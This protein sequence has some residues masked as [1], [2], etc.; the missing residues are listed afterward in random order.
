MARRGTLKF[1]ND[2]GDS[3]QQSYSTAEQSTPRRARGTLTFSEMEPVEMEKTVDINQLKNRVDSAKK[4]WQQTS[5]ISAD[6]SV[7]QSERDARNNYKTLLK[8]YKT[9]KA[10]QD[11]EEQTRKAQQEYD[12]LRGAD[13]NALKAKMDAAKESADGSAKERIV[14]GSIVKQKDSGAQAVYEE[15]ARKYNLAKQIQYDERGTE[16]LSKLSEEQAAAVETLAKSK[17]KDRKIDMSGY[18]LDDENRYNAKQK[19]LAD[20]FTEQEI[21]DLED[22]RA[23]QI[24]SA[25]YDKAVQKREDLANSGVL[26]AAVATVASVPE[27]LTS[28]IGL[29]D[30]AMQVAQN[31]GTDRPANYKRTAMRPYAKANAARSTISGNL[32]Q[33][34][35]AEFLGQNVASGAYNI[36]TSMLD[37]AATLGLTALGIPPMA[38]TSLLGGAAATSAMVDAHE[39]GVSDEQAV[40]SGAAAGVAETLFEEVSLEKLL[41][42]KPV[43]GDLSRRVRTTLKNIGLQ[44]A[45]EGSEEV[46]TTIANTV[47]DHLINGSL[48]EMQ[49]NIKAYMDSGMTEGEARARAYIDLGKQL[50][51]DFTGGAISGGIMSGVRTGIETAKADA[52]LRED[53]GAKPNELIEEG[54]ATDDGSKA[55]QL[56]QK[57]SQQVEGGK[58]LSQRQVGKLVRANEAYFLSEDEATVQSAVKQ[59]LMEL[60]ETGDIEKISRALTRQASGEDL[61]IAD[62]RRIARSEAA[63][64]ISRDLNPENENEWAKGIGT[65]KLNREAYNADLVDLA[66]RKAARTEAQRAA[67]A[68]VENSEGSS[69]A[70]PQNRAVGRTGMDVT[71]ADTGE[72]LGSVKIQ[73]IKDGKL[74]L[75]T[76]DGQIVDA[77]KVKFRT[78]GERVVYSA[79]AEMNLNPAIAQSIVDNYDNSV[80]GRIYAADVKLAYQYGRMNFPKSEL[81]KLDIK[82]Y[83]A[84]HAYNLGRAEVRTEQPKQDVKVTKKKRTVSGGKGK[85]VFETSTDEKAMTDIQRESLNGIKLLAELSNVEFH[86]YESTKSGNSFVYEKPDGVKT[87]A[88]GWY[89]TGTNQIWVD[90]NAGN[91]GEGT[92]L[93]T[94]AHEISHYIKEWSPTKWR[95]MADYLI[96]QYGEDVPLDALLERQMEKLRSRN[97]GAKDEQLMDE[98]HEELVSDALSEMLVDGKVADKL[99]ALKKKDRSLWTKIK[100]AVKDLLERWG[101]IRKQYEGR[102]PDAGEAQF[103]RGMDEAFS[104]IQTMYA[105][106]FADADVNF[107]QAMQ[108]VVKPGAAAIS[109]SEILT[110]GAV[111]TDGETRHSIRS[112]KADIAEGQMFEDLKERCGWSQKQVDELRGKLTELVAYMEP[113]REILD[114]NEAYGRAGRRY[115]PYKPNSDPLY[116][117]SMDFSTLCSKR[118]LTQYVIESLQVRE[119]RPMSAEEQM[120][121]RDMLNEYRQVEKGLQVACAMCYVEAARLKS[122]KQIQRWLDDPAARMRDYL[123]PNN[124][125]FK[126]KIAEM[127]ADF[128]ESLGYDRS[129][130]QTKM[131]TADK[132]EL[133]RRSKQ[134]RGEYQPSAEEQKII[135][136]AAVLPK[137]TYLTAANLARLR[138]TD[139]VI[140]DAYSNFVRAATHS[141]ALETDE[142]YYYGDSARDNGNGIKVSDK[143]IEKVN[144]ENGMRFSSWSDWR[145]QHMLDY[146]TAVIDNS[147]RGAAMHG[148]TKFPDEVRV[149][150]KTGM[151]FNLSGVA[152]TQ[153]GLNPDGSLSFSDTESINIEEAKA[154]REEFPETA[155]LQ[156]IGVSDE[157]IRALMRSEDVDYIIPYHTSS[158]NKDL[159]RMAQIHGWK[160]YT[161]I[162]NAG[163]IKSAKDNGENNWQKEPVFSEFF[164]GYDTG[165]NGIDAMR[166]S[167]KR[168][169]EMCGERGLHPKFEK[170]AD[171]PNY[172]KLLIDRKMVNQNT[173]ELIRQKPVTPT[174]DWDV[175]RDVVDRY[176]ANY[177]G[178][179]EA[180]ALKHVVDNWD[181]I[182][183][184]IRDLK[185][186]KAKRA[187]DTVGSEMLAARP[188][189]STVSITEAMPD[190]VGTYS[191]GKKYSERVTDKDTLDFLENQDTITTYKTMQFVDG[192]LY[193][194]MA[195]RVNGKYEDESILGQWE[196]AV[197]H[198]EFVDSTGKF[199]LDK[200]VGQGSLKAA[201]NPYMHSSNL[202]LNDQFSGA[203]ARPQLVTVECE[204]PASEA[205]SGYHAL[206]AKDA[207]GWH[208]WHTGTVA[209]QVRKARGIERQVFLSRWIKP[210]RIVPDSEVAGMYKDILSDTGIEVPDNVVPPSL[211][212]EL[213][214]VGV[215]I[216][217]S[218][219]VKY[220]TRDSSGRELTAAQQDYFRDS[221]VRDSDGNLLVLYH[222]TGADFNV[223][224]RSKIGE[225]WG[226]ISDLGFYFTPYEE[227]AAGYA[228]RDRDGN[229][230]VKQ[231]Y[232]NLKN[233]LI[234]EGSGWG[235]AAGQADVRHGDLK[236]WAREGGHDGIIVRSTDELMYDDMPDAVYIAFESKQIKNVT[237][238]NPTEDA[239]IRYSVREEFPNEID[240]WAREGMRENEQFT[241]GSTGPV[242][243][244][245]G[246]IE[247]DI[248]MRGDKIKKILSDHPEMTLAEIKKIPRILEDPVLVLKSTGK[249]TRG[250]NSRLV[251]FGADKAANGHHIMTVMDLLPVE[252]GFAVNDMQ[253]S[254]SSYTKKNEASFIEN[255]DVLFADKKRAIPF[256][257]STGLTIASQPLL[258]NGYVGSITYPDGNVNI[259]GAPFYSV[260]RKSTNSERGGMSN[261]EILASVFMDAAKNEIE[262]GKIREY[263]SKIEEQNAEEAKLH[264]VRAQLKEA[265]F[266]PGKKDK[267]KIGQLRD[268]ATRLANRIS[269]R[270]KQLLR[271][272]A[273][274]PL[275]AVLEREK[276]LA[277]KRASAK[278]GDRVEK[279]RTGR[280]KTEMRHKVQKIAGELNRLLLN[281]DKEHN[282]KIGLQ[283]ATAEALSAINMETAD[284][285]ARL[286]KLQKRIDKAS[287]PA[288]RAKLLQTYERVEQMGANM[289]QRLS[290]LKNA[291]D[292]IKDSTDPLIANAYQPEIDQMIKDLRETVGNTPLHAMSL[293]QL[294]SVYDT[295]KAVLTT[296]RKANKAFK[297]ERNATISGMGEDVMREIRRTGGNHPLELTGAGII[298]D[299][300]WSLLKPVYAFKMIG[301]DTLSE[302]F[303]NVRAGE[304]TWAVDVSDAKSFYADARRKYHYDDW[305][306]EKAYTF[307]SKSGKEFRLNLGQIMSLYAYSKRRAADEHLD[308][309]GFVFERDSV[310]VVEKK[311]G[312]PLKYTVKTSDAY[313]LSIDQLSEICGTLTSE[314]A[315]F[316]DEMQAYLSD[317]MGEKGNEVA[318]EMYGIKLFTEKNYFP[319]KSARQ[320]MYEKNEVT[321]E[322]RIK[323]SGFTKKTVP[324]A[325]NPVILSDFMSVWA[326]HVSDMAMYHAFVLPLE[327][328]NRVFNYRTVNSADTDLQSVK[329]TL[330]NA[331]GG[332]AEAYIKQLLTDLNGGA[333]S[334]PHAGLINKSISL[335]KKAAT[336]ASASVVIQQPSA[337]A[338]AFAYID[339]K[340]FKGKPGIRTWDE[341]KKYAP[342][343]VIKE[344]G[345][346]DTNMGRSTEEYITGREYEGIKEK[347]SA[348]ISDPQYRD[349]VLGK[350]PALADELAWC[351]IWQAA[352]NEIA[353]KQG[354]TG[355]ALKQVA[356]KRFTEVIV[357]TQ[358]YD[359]VVSRSG[360]M[361]SK[362]T[363]AKMTTAFMAEPITS[364]NMI[365]DAIVKGKRGNK[366]FTGRAIGAVA[367][368]IILNSILV[369]F[370]YA[371]RNDDDD[372]S[373]AEKYAKELTESLIDGF[374][375]GNMIPFVRDI[376]SIFQG[377]DV[378]RSDM[379][380][381]SN[382]YKSW[383]N[384]W[385][386]NRTPYR[387][388]EDFAGS[389]ASLFGLPVKNIMR[390]ARGMYTMADTLISGERTTGRG[391]GEA[392]LQG[393]GRERKD[394]DQLYSA[395]MSGDE[396][397]AQRIKARYEDERKAVYAVRDGLYDNDKRITQAAQARVDG[398]QSEYL[399]I[400]KE[401]VAEKHF[402]Q[403]EVIR[404]INYATDKLRKGEGES[405][406]PESPDTFK[407]EEYYDEIMANDRAEAAVIKKTILEDK[408][409]KGKSEDE[410]AKSFKSSFKTVV[411]NAFE[412]GEIDSGKAQS[413]LVSYGDQDEAAAKADVAGWQFTRDY[414]DET[415]EDSW[416]D[417]YYKYATDSGVPINTYMQYRDKVRSITGKGRKEAR[418]AVIDSLPLSS[419]QKDAL[420]YSEGWA[421]STIG[422]APWH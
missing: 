27:T 195:A 191:D 160:D 26:G 278:W 65:S 108:A 187:V 149:L 198:P 390:D 152:G 308:K 237:N 140:Y 62:R 127:Q 54:L 244:G 80:D 207:V 226:N 324:H 333:R 305:D 92:M 239:D 247:S 399:S 367:A 283:K 163:K 186:G 83:Q 411:K 9:L 123:G 408:V 50:S 69:P 122:P 117:I 392:V 5:T 397:Q 318:L 141:K 349:E 330:Q 201:Y 422:D 109:E 15:A 19:L 151:M 380:V 287:D 203:Y 189:E 297:M 100:D 334:D 299:F 384:L 389:V 38:A 357:N 200:G 120:A 34:T 147:V 144:R 101:V 39:R 361:R 360:I 251:I 231:V 296:I 77:D 265:S 79:V 211:L 112:M 179:M 326:K 173:G 270:D 387:K 230:R 106:A 20:G 351:Q 233:P 242:L 35:D 250:M 291:Y 227:D 356:G 347:M 156:C 295:Y 290:A 11:A 315:K 354:L 71:S 76:E 119:G 93:Y 224:D 419:A 8:Q 194:P 398:N 416:F 350:A 153:T 327:D 28:G 57:Y 121:I 44:A 3:G 218:G 310:K 190:A 379:S 303:D 393:L 102:T 142:P 196:Q 137:E 217:E 182:P 276:D 193:P 348:V 96:E 113:H 157:H 420:Y 209:G 345:Y 1:Y 95:A 104:K 382:I 143:F 301:S 377:Y 212:E 255:S 249:Q 339:P 395:L 18:G 51:L 329:A 252:N 166:E 89:V 314:Q 202:V 125:G 412:D 267:A 110:D 238:Q 263:Q 130:P 400:A 317:V 66:A 158:L 358:V 298:K 206:Y 222:G 48:S 74:T 192:K 36:G 138:E 409:K 228:R 107:A 268:A 312:V 274:K 45:T 271:L 139:P 300:S 91:A 246:A 277:Y 10:Q 261:R 253:K 159:R 177:D 260:F 150:G 320:F 180:R 388:V 313:N 25:K 337:I 353:D 90:L 132:N 319:L 223:F 241:L 21:S 365:A 359:S 307:H 61:T 22:W 172:W 316:V 280:S 41:S 197:E 64:Q 279:M 273:S 214:K 215:P 14:A 355:E 385:S 47:T 169:V 302:L 328:F 220:S 421:A 321:Q 49:Q 115:S 29:I 81:E 84:E 338:R 88:N 128:K 171:D 232:L 63:Q 376:I 344:M 145:I 216:K 381:V 363:G 188:K 219:K 75:K 401:I 23:R 53:Y 184:R 374:N 284:V 292:D 256:L 4:A 235:S 70:A 167:A 332:Q 67:Q 336:F 335:F 154:L 221:Q 366:K 352:Q 204:V 331:Y 325:S 402:T 368:S 7:N 413:L 272:E 2:G 118:L 264:E 72:L 210:V 383:K 417:A 126:S 373:Y 364:L 213:K 32:E 94:A 111:V 266:S 52:R 257:R 24:D 394:S 229:R 248:Y 133:Q 105:E 146:I 164:V 59:R 42:L 294:K 386:S 131:R 114:M 208:A 403:D 286:A 181:T 86:V 258:R 282:V 199:K 98:A 31:K 161:G 293:Q 135:D 124:K 103:L 116:D 245:L 309:G 370:V 170:F 396:K 311:K 372:K 275:M 414:P 342:V 407:I 269:I 254:T 259:D 58:N 16:A 405:S 37:S 306:L 323:N 97:P 362:D 346:F 13:L 289:T 185:A 375:P 17:S 134:M 418:M 404:A 99:A 415:A 55:Y 285:E 165:M 129:T 304:D 281:G 78:E 30:L 73:S 236:R 43:Q 343:A 406:A 168:Y 322:T 178:G 175:I 341:L 378:E 56:A 85:V 46:F 60:G 262:R 369:A 136:W 205:T 148:Y 243:Q 12:E 162:Q 155:G 40:L 82:P 234:I 410:A 183:Q 225:N 33:T 371:M 68:S 288:E 6:G 391:I 176:V 340:Y 240:E 87:T 174:F